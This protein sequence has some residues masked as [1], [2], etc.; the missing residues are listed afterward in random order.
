MSGWISFIIFGVLFYL[1]MRSGC[2]AH[3]VHGGHGNHRAHTGSHGSDAKQHPPTEDPVCGMKVDSSK[4]FPMMYDGRE[5]RF[6]SKRCLDR[7]EAEPQRY[8][9]QKGGTEK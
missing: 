5:Y 8:L 4:G 3:A 1:L 9:Q 6:C 2:G 7:F